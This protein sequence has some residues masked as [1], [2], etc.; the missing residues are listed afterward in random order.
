M[1][2][3]Q[4]KI[5]LA[6]LAMAGVALVL[7]LQKQR[8]ERVRAE[9]LALQ[10]HAAAATTQHAKMGT[11]GN[12]PSDAAETAT[13]REQRAEL[14]RLRGEVTRLRNQLRQNMAHAPSTGASAA[15]ATAANVQTEADSGPFT[16][17][18]TVNV[19]S[20]EAFA[21]GGWLTSPGFRTFMLA[22]PRLGAA[23]AD[24][25][26]I[27]ISMCLLKVAESEVPEAL[28]RSLQ[29]PAQAQSAVLAG[30]ETE[31]LRNLI[32]SGPTNNIISRP[33]IA[34]SDGVPA[35]LFVGESRPNS[36]GTQREVGTRINL[37]PQLSQDGRTIQMG[38]NVE[39]TPRE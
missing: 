39:Y 12:Q 38:V 7:L 3:T 28:L 5:V 15:D 2:V 30:G 29:D 21:A 19:G 9:N 35:S 18:A 10:H 24:G 26:P 37:S 14:L 33:R 31:F 6:A 11:S 34:T 4:M 13:M 16:A 22:T 20:G 36:D 27:N 1:Q 32:A 17:S 25:R 23:T 8:L